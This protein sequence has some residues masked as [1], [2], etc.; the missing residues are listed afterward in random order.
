MILVFPF[1]TDDR[2]LRLKQRWS[3]GMLDTLGI[4]LDADLAHLVPGSMLVANH[5]SWLDI[6]V[7]NAARPCAF[8]SKEE[9]RHWPVIGWLAT[10]NDTVFLKRGSRGHAKLINQEIA[11]IL[12]TGKHVAVFPE[13]T[14]TD[15]T[16]LLHFHAAL[17]QPAL[18]A[19]RP[20][21][22]AA[23]SYWEP[24]GS[25]SLA[26]RYDGDLS[27]GDCLKAVLSRRRLTARLVATPAQGLNGEDRRTVAAAA[28]AAITAAAQLPP[29]AREPL[30]VN[31]AEPSGSDLP[32]AARSTPTPGLTT[33]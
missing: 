21:V 15:G 13:G 25:R 5:I 18:A 29:A 7:V 11:E 32:D 3:R 17:L 30:A 1:C 16:H 28:H 9:V 12:G 27:L 2:R 23:I 20:V 19:G 33:G 10:M 26:P 14:T 4:R 22:P 8:V 6:F 31:P 24:D